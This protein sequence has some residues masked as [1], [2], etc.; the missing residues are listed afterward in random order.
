M[1][2]E[3]QRISGT[4]SNAQLLADVR[5][6]LSERLAQGDVGLG[7]VARALHMSDRTLRRRLSEHGTSYQ[8]L[9]D[10][11]RAGVACK[12]VEQAGPHTAFTR[13]LGLGE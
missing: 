4:L 3:P 7:S 9:L 13:R 1:A 5:A 11:V 2:H 8:S 12:L 6:Q 10:E